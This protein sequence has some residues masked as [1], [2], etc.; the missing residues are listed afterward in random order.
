MGNMTFV[1]LMDVLLKIRS[2]SF[3]G[4]AI[5]NTKVFGEVY[6]NTLILLRQMI[7]HHHHQHAELE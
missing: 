1:G 3:K 2:Y 6:T 4:I 5:E 7:Y